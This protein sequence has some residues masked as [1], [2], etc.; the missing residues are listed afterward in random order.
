MEQIAITEK[1]GANYHL[2]EL[3]GALN[4]YT[5][6][7]F[8][9][10]LYD[11]VHKNNI[12]LDMSKLVELDPAGIGFLMA[13]FNESDDVGHK[14]VVEGGKI[15]EKTETGCP[16]GTTITVQ[17]LFFNTPVRYKFLKKNYTEAGYI[18][19]AITRIALVNK[20]VSIKL[21]SDGK[22]I[23]QTN[24]NGNLKDVIY[25]IKHYI[26]IFK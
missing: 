22:T 14:I 15:I 7:E 13:A 3:E 10:T 17:N 4:A 20:N 2:Y 9:D 12:V 8:Q 1:D 18:E 24:G 5:L 6:G 25:S 23:V 21:I 19:D 11:A 16:V 26:E